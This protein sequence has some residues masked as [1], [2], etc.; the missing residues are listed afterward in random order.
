[1]VDCCGGKQNKT[2]YVFW[3]Q[4]ESSSNP[5]SAGLP[6]KYCLYFLRSSSIIYRAVMVMWLVVDIIGVY[7]ILLSPFGVWS[8]HMNNFG[9][10]VMSRSDTD[11]FQP[12][13]VKSHCT[14]F[15][16]LFPISSLK[17]ALCWDDGTTKSK[18]PDT[19][20]WVEDSCPRKLSY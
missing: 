20:H 6:R 1:M 14:I 4:T 7:H 9:K 15:Q 16:S 19:Y 17:E 2:K 3:S 13:A 18:Y 11:H 8:T 5:G 12:K 10:W